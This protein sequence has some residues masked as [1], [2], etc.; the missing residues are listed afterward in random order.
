[1]AVWFPGFWGWWFV[2]GGG[3]GVRLSLPRPEVLG[4]ACVHV[5]EEEGERVYRVEC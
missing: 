5:D 4:H 3:R 1:M 2:V